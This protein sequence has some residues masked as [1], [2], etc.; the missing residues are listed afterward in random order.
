MAESYAKLMGV[1]IAAIVIAVAAIFVASTGTNSMVTA[2]QIGSDY[3]PQVREIHLF[4][5]V[6]ENIDEDKFGVPP[7]LYS[8]DQIVVNKGDTVRVNF[9]NLEPVETQEYH[10]FT[11]N[12]KPY[13]VKIDVNASDK[14]TV[15]FVATE[16]GIFQYFCEYH[17]P[18]MA[19]QFVVQ[20][21]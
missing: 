1:S 11:I 19:G 5:K 2:Q 7:D 8:S 12:D 20:D 15:E 18:T 13:N 17:L 21:T 10:T 6:D 14:A 4:T 9:Y 16:S 3:D